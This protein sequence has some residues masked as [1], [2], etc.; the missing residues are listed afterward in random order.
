MR[1]CIGSSLPL[2]K[3]NCLI[4]EL[5]CQPNGI[6]FAAK[7]MFFKCFILWWKIWGLKMQSSLC[8]ELPT[9][10]V[11]NTESFTVR[12]KDL[13]VVLLIQSYHGTLKTE[14]SALP[15]ER[16][17]HAHCFQVCFVKGNTWEERK[18]AWSTVLIPPSVYKNCPSILSFNNLI[19][20]YKYMCECV[21]IYILKTQQYKKNTTIWQAVNYRYQQY[22]N[23]LC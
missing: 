15:S 16:T 3:K 6:Y 10:K 20:K 21:C 12:A 13:P 18:D 14:Y 7:C 8:L 19:L 22:P 11:W 17:D 1:C 4:R 2:G 9:L 5:P 23:N